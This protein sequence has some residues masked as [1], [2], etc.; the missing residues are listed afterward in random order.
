MASMADNSGIALGTAEGWVVKARA[1][2]LLRPG[3]H[4]RARLATP[5]VVKAR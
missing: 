5:R 1:R 2:A 3:H 4:E